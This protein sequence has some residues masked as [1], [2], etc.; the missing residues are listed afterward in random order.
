[1]RPGFH[2]W[3]LCT[4]SGCIG[5]ALKKSLPDLCVTLSD[6]SKDALSLARENIC[7]NSVQ[8][9]VLEGDFLN[10]FQGSKADFVVSNPPYVSTSEWASLDPSVR[11]YE[12]KTA[13]CGGEEGFDFYERLQRELPQFLNPKAQVFLEIGAGMGEG[14]EKIFSHGPWGSKQLLSDWSGKSRFFFLEMQ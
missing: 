3:D 10:P 2:L 8:V 6:L 7:L 12:P 5:I 13:L 11:L 1:M 4:G 14:I 9:E